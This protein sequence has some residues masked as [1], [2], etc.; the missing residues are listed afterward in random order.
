MLNKV[1]NNM[2][3][4]GNRINLQFKAVALFSLIVLGFVSPPGGTAFADDVTVDPGDDINFVINQTGAYS[5]KLRYHAK[6]SDES[7]VAGVD[8]DSIDTHVE[9]AAGTSQLKVGTKTYENS[10]ADGTLSFDVQFVN[11]QYYDGSNWINVQHPTTITMRYSATG[12]IYYP[13]NAP[14]GGSGSGSDENY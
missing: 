14:S 4:K 5:V 8:Y 10:D 12:R 13:H 3:V 6:S 2:R 11:P 1:T 7:A 9:I